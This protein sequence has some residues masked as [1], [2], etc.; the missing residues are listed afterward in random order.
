LIDANPKDD[1][2]ISES[3]WFRGPRPKNLAYQTSLGRLLHGKAEEILGSS[4]ANTYSNRV[5]LVFT[6]PPFPLNRK[7]KYGN[8][9]GEEYLKWLSSFGPLLRELLADD[10]SLVVE[11]GNAWE[12][13]RPAMS[14]LP[15][16]SLLALKEAGEFVL[17]QEFIWFNPAR[18][19]S[20][21]QWVNIERI[22]VKDSFTRFWWLAKH[23]RPKADNR[24]VLLNYSQAME[25]LLRTQRYNHGERPSEFVIGEESFLKDNGGAIPPNVIVAYNTKSRDPYLDYCRDEGLTPHPARMP[26]SIPQFFIRLLTEPEQIVLDP[27]AGSN[28]TGAA[29]ESLNRRWI[30]FEAEESYARGSWGRFGELAEED[31]PTLFA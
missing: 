22:R 12:P 20:P 28:T 31:R 7:K 26:I 1:P 5:Q 18:L 19:P 11:V 17:C 10:G 3:T 15:L 8:L 21:A 16:E 30:A 24:A 6:S 9:Q 27:F 14:T 25:T 13:G 2:L 29:A 23:D 4:F